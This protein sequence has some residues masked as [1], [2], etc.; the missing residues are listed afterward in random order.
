M[1][2]L[3]FTICVLFVSMVVHAAQSMGSRRGQQ[4]SCDGTNISRIGIKDTL[5][6]PDVEGGHDFELWRCADGWRFHNSAGEQA[7]IKPLPNGRFKTCVVNASTEKEFCCP[8]APEG[9]QV[10]T[11]VK[12]ENR[13]AHS[14]AGKNSEWH[15]GTLDPSSVDPKT[16]ASKSPENDYLYLMPTDDNG[17]FSD[18]R[19]KITGSTGANRSSTDKT[20]TL[21][22]TAIYP[23][24]TQEGSI[25][26]E[27]DTAA[28]GDPKQCSADKE[29]GDFCQLKPNLVNNYYEMNKAVTKGYL[30]QSKPGG[31]GLVPVVTE[32]ATTA[33]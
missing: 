8:Q 26:V 17:K 1:R 19:Y 9:R 31:G 6:F 14:M 29:V 30:R 16:G 21:K 15:C 13:G 32:G 25:E 20:V 27:H 18:V 24:K 28:G 2:H 22:I 5:G 10:Q 4:H 11:K 7:Y 23:N 3:L 12:Q 33:K